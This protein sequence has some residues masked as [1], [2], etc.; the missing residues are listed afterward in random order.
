MIK[1]SWKCGVIADLLQ[2]TLND[3]SA[4]LVDLERRGLIEAAG[5]DLRLTDI[6]A[7]EA[8]AD[9]IWPDNDTAQLLRLSSLPA[10]RAA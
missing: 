7:L 2:L 5:E 4:V 1:D 9:G 8:M 10:Y 3:L 6:A